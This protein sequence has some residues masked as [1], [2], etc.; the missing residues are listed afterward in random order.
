MIVLHIIEE[1][2]GILILLGAQP[3]SQ[4]L[5]ALEK[6]S[7]EALLAMRDDLVDEFETKNPG[8]KVLTLEY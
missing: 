3:H 6:H 8:R 4:A 2:N 1:I 7:P 5:K